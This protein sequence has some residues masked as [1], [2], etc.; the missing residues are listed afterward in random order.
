MIIPALAN[1]TPQ[2]IHQANAF[3]DV[4]G[5]T[6]PKSVCYLMDLQGLTIASSNRDRPDSFLGKS[7]AFRPYF[8]QAIQGSA[9]RYC[10]PG[11]HLQGIGVLRQFP[12]AGRSREN[13]RGGSHQKDPQR[14]KSLIHQHHLGL[15]ID[16]HGIVVMSNRS[17]MILKKPLASVTCG[18]ERTACLPPVWRWPFYANPAPEAGG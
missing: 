18:K 4:F 2:N 8:Q 16:Q 15:I 3:L 17:D 12:G 1:R 9:G 14:F 7:Y 6:L 10:G 5:K 13:H 11:S